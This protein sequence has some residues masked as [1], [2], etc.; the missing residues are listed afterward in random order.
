[1]SGLPVASEVTVRI[2]AQIRQLYGAQSV[3]RLQAATVAELI[4]ALDRRY[5]GMGERLAEPD[6]RPRRWVQFFVAG[7]DV[8][9]LAME[10]TELAAGVE[11]QIVPAAAG[12]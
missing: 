4:Q 10:M 1:M 6:G 11:V 9:H 5:P 7:T 8:R 2:P 12:G 3:E